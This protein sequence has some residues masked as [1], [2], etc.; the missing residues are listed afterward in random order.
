M[1]DFI[2]PTLPL[3]LSIHLKIPE[4]GLIAM[5]ILSWGDEAN[6][7]NPIRGKYLFGAFSDFIVLGSVMK[8]R[9]Q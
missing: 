5:P 9:D 7:D 2:H 6:R 4:N 3:S 8:H 1:N